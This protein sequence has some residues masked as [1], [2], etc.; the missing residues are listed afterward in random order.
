MTEH[1]RPWGLFK[2]KIHVDGESPPPL[3][4]NPRKTRHSAVK[5]DADD[6]HVTVCY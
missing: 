3:R 5:Y 4:L 1:T 2:L 6:K